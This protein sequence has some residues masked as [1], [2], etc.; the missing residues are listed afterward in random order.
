MKDYEIDRLGQVVQARVERFAGDYAEDI[1]QE[2]RLLAWLQQELLDQLAPRASEAWVLRSAH[3]KWINWYRKE[4]GPVIRLLNSPELEVPEP[5]E[6]Q[7]RH[8]GQAGAIRR[9]MA[10]ARAIPQPP[11]LELLEDREAF[12][13]LADAMVHLTDRQKLVIGLLFYQYKSLEE[14]ASR[15]NVST[16]TVTN[17]KNSALAVLAQRLTTG[18]DRQT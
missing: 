14:V 18:V 1:A 5:T 17:I 15:L 7:R 13:D 10:R 3:R 12:L 8:Q 16:R 11:P 6:T 9:G 4:S 2:A